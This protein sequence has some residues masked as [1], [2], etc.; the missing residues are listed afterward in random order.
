MPVTKQQI[1]SN[2]DS[3][4]LLPKRLPKDFGQ[5]NSL[6]KDKAYL[7]YI[8]LVPEKGPKLP[9]RMWF[10]K[11]GKLPYFER[12][13]EVRANLM[14]GFPVDEASYNIGI[15]Q[16]SIPTRKMA[17][18]FPLVEATRVVMPE[19]HQ[20]VLKFSPQPPAPTCLPAGSEPT[21]LQQDWQNLADK[22]MN[23]RQIARM[24]HQTAVGMSAVPTIL[25]NMHRLMTGLIGEN[26]RL[27][28]EPPTR[29]PAPRP[30]STGSNSDDDTDGEDD[31]DDD[32]NG[33]GARRHS[34]PLR[35]RKDVSTFIQ[36]VSQEEFDIAQVK[37]AVESLGS[38]V[39][40]LKSD[41]SRKEHLLSLVEAFKIEP[42]QMSRL[43]VRKSLKDKLVALGWQPASEKLLDSIKEEK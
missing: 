23:E 27:Q 22:P 42:K 35:R 21:G 28:A 32:S 34:S 30:P 18:Q 8:D 3:T 7:Q 10:R 24:Q 19:S 26:G 20:S 29:G 36:N 16:T 14:F 1:V 38:S 6:V 15:A 39:F 2:R 31:E 12:S 17:L 41:K 13:K 4:K 25:E 5:R 11:P 43:S 33:R 9:E 40:N 37:M